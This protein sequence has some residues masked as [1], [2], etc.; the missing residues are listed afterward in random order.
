MSAHLGIPG[1]ADRGYGRLPDCNRGCTSCQSSAINQRGAH[2][3]ECRF[4]VLG[5]HLSCSGPR[6]SGVRTQPSAGSG[7]CSCRAP[8]TL[9]RCTLCRLVRHTVISP[10][11]ADSACCD[12]HHSE[13]NVKVRC[14]PSQG[15]A[16]KGALALVQHSSSL[17]EAAMLQLFQAFQREIVVSE[18]PQAIRMAAMQLLDS[19]AQVS[20]RT[21]STQ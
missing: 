11:T 7:A 18:L 12:D 3:A 14:R 10:V 20:V 13:F 21:C 6:A 1:A 4:H 15:P 2:S 16:L 8:G 17:P 5:A 19:A 9:L